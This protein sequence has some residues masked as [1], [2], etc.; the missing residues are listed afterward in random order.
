MREVLLNTMHQNVNTISTVDF[1]KNKFEEIVIWN[2][3]YLDGEI[4][5]KPGYKRVI[6]KTVSLS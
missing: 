2:P 1:E 6:R 4:E 3:T 5:E